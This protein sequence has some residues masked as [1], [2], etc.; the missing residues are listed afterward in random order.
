M[1]MERQHK[2]VKK[3][4]FSALLIASL[5]IFTVWLAGRFATLKIDWSFVIPTASLIGGTVPIVWSI[6]NWINDKFEEKDSKIKD[7]L[8]AKQDEIEQLQADYQVLS[9][10][11]LEMRKEVGIFRRILYKIEARLEVKGEQ[12]SGEIASLKNTLSKVSNE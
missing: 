4:L 3:V 10:K 5:I 12:C 8:T 6:L 2:R 7:E 9:E 1:K 11:V